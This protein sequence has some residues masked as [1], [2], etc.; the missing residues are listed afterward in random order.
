MS[1]LYEK[2][3]FNNNNLMYFH[4]REEFKDEKI[5][6]TVI[7]AEGRQTD[8]GLCADEVY[9]LNKTLGRVLNYTTANDDVIM[10]WEAENV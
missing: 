9:K 3:E 2:L 1:D 5:T 8:V 6:F 4:H 10:S 7:D